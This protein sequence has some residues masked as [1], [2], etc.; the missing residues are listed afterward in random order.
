[1]NQALAGNHPQ[2]RDRVRTVL[3]Y[4]FAGL[5]LL[6]VVYDLDWGELGRSVLA[7]RWIWIVPAMACDILSYIAQGIRWRLL[8]RPVGDLPVL[9]TTQAIYSGLFINEVVPLRAGEMA[10]VFLVSRWLGADLVAV[11]PSLAVERLMD[12]IWLAI[13]IGLT[14]IFL[15][16]PPV[17]LDAAEIFGSIVLVLVGLFVFIVLRRK[18]E[19]AGPAG[20]LPAGQG[21]LRKM[22]GVPGQLGAGIRAI[23]WSRHLYGAFLASFFLLLLQTVAFWL[24]MEACG[25]RLQG[26]PVSFWIGAAVFLIVHFGTAIPNAPANVGS[27]QFFT[28]LGLSLFGMNKTAATAFSLVV[29]II[30]TIPLWGLGFLALTRSGATL[31]GIKDE[32]RNLAGRF[33]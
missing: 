31:A 33:R 29:F 26:R 22:A 11:I 18:G 14:A 28:V 7:V 16:L 19:P 4:L 2:T 32:I 8:L 17:L 12:A 5:C 13:G 20:K 15:P 21:W 23:G 25:L 27:Y 3:G 1:M 6:W 30:L 24:V 10:R 9:L